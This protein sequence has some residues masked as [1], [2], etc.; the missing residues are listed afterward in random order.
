MFASHVHNEYVHR[1]H[2]ESRTTA[3]F[4]GCTLAPMED[5]FVRE[6]LSGEEIALVVVVVRT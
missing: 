5:R 3:A 1:S 2:T 6:T 4:F